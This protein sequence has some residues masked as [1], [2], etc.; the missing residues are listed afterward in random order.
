MR[1]AI[2][3][4]ARAGRNDLA[5]DLNRIQAR[6]D[7]DDLDVLRCVGTD[8]IADSILEAESFS[9]LIALLG[10]LAG[11]MSLS[12]FTLHVI[13]E[14]ASTNFSTKVLT[15]YPE[16]WISHYVERRYFV[17]D[18]VARTCLAT[19]D[20]FF[21][22]RFERTAPAARSFWEDAAAHGVGPAGYTRPIVTERGDRLAISVCSPLDPE[23][24][25]DRF[26]RFEDDLFSLGMYLADTFCR[27]A[28]A[29]RPDTFN[30]TDDQLGILRALALGVT[31]ESLRQ[32]SYRNDSYAALESSIC[33]LFRTRTVVQAAILATRIGLLADA[34]LTKSDILAAADATAVGRLIVAPTGAP[35][36]R[37]ARLRTPSPDPV[38][39]PAA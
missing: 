39:S 35:L 10:R 22:D 14:A 1:E 32:R 4:L 18:P 9:E 38:R 8:R 2:D 29:E 28:S 25:R 19:D 34:P 30:P 15:T 20:G 6:V 7:F 12:H 11:A 27:L 3:L 37:L 21:W 17:V 36:R 13:S 16:E 5:S 33:T 24:F 23:T 31:E 26:E